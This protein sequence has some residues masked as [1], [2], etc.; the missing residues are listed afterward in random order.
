MRHLR[1]GRAPYAV[2]AD[3]DAA[4]LA[5]LEP[6]RVVM[7]VFALMGALVG[8]A[9]TLNAVRFDAVPGNAGVG[10]EMKAI[11]AVVVGGAAISGGRGTLLGTVLGVCL[12]GVIG[13]ALS[14]VGISPFWEKAVQ[15]AVI[16]AALVAESMLKAVTRPVAQGGRAPAAVR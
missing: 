7:A 2:G 5:G 14:F 6:A 3:A 9:A 12:L 8:L 11:A 1:A 15:G 16:L 10:L 4:R 13:T